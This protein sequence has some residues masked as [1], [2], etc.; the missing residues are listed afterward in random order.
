MN[1]KKMMDLSTAHMPSP[2]PDWGTL[3]VYD[4]EYGC[5][6]FPID[7]DLE[8]AAKMGAM[9]PEWFRPINKAAFEAECMIVNFDRDANEDEQFQTYEWEE[10]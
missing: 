3:R 1:I 6:V 9:I 10:T 2:N 5:V 7:P 8:V 4:S